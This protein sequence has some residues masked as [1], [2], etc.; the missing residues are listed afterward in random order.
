MDSDPRTR[1]IPFQSSLGLFVLC[2]AVLIFLAVYNYRVLVLETNDRVPPILQPVMQFTGVERTV[3]THPAR[4]GIFDSLS[5]RRFFREMNVNHSESVR[6]WLSFTNRLGL[7]ASTFQSVDELSSFDIV[8]LPETVSLS[9]YETRQLK[10]FI[11]GGGGIFLV[12]AV[13]SRDETGRWQTLPFFGD[14]VGMRF[15]GNANPS[16]L[17]PARL[18]IENQA[19]IS[20]SWTPRQQITVPSYNQVLVGRIVEQRATPVVKTAFFQADDQ[21]LRLSAFAY[22]P[23]LS[24]RFVWSGFNLSPQ[25]PNDATGERA[26]DELF[27]ESLIWLSNLPR[28]RTPVWPRG[29][30]QALSLVLKLEPAD[31][32]RLENF[33]N[34]RLADMPVTLLIPSARM[35]EYAKALGPLPTGV[36][37]ALQVSQDSLRHY[38]DPNDAGVWLRTQRER[39]SRLFG[40]EVYGL[41]MY[42]V[43]PRVY[44]R[45]ALRSGFTYFLAEPTGEIEDFPEIFATAR[46][47]G[48]LRPPRK[49]AFAPFQNFQ[50]DEEGRPSGIV[51][52]NFGELFGPEPKFT[53]GDLLRDNAVWLSTV[54]ENVRWRTVR[55]A[56]VMDRE[57]LPGGRLRINLSNGSYETLEDFPFLVTLP[58]A[59]Q[60]VAVWPKA[61]RMRAPQSREVEPGLWEFSLDEF[62]GG[63]TYEF[64]LTPNL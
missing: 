14:I 44:S 26:I 47:E 40:R 16:P 64:I 3:E 60:S 52:V 23:Y 8:I 33:R 29:N 27:S 51:L 53:A 55:N 62:V 20:L 35:D 21:P 18:A 4:V 11:A 59:T 32:P 5:T 19:E 58:R 43:S 63:R 57:F 48:L 34:S 38:A 12:G 31:L 49:I 50:P 45:V 13:G 41:R 42:R 30:D 7:D 17:G 10:S 24:G 36:E 39:A 1:G 6:S 46:L 22:G 9:A 2:A 37:V 54:A 56:V 25:G 28:V 15:V 61:V